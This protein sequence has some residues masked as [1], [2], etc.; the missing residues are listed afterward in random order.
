MENHIQLYLTYKDQTPSAGTAATDLIGDWTVT[1]GPIVYQA[2]DS[3]VADNAMLVAC[4]NVTLPDGSTRKMAVVAIAGTAAMSTVD[5]E[6]EDG[7]AGDGSAITGVVPWKDFIATPTHAASPPVA[8]EAVISVGT[9]TGLCTLLGMTDPSL[10]NAPTL[11]QHLATLDADILVVTGHSLGGALSA[12]LGL[13]LVQTGTTPQIATTYVYPTAGAS[14]GNDVFART[15][16]QALPA[17]RGA[18]AWQSWNLDIWNTLDVVP[19]AWSTVGTDPTI[20]TLHNVNV[21][22]GNDD[23]CP[24]R[25]LKIPTPGHVK[26]LSARLLGWSL[27]STVA[28]TPIPGASFPG[29][30]VNVIPDHPGSDIGMPVLVPPVDFIGFAAQALYQHGMAYGIAIFADQTRRLPEDQSDPAPN[31]TREG[32]KELLGYFETLFKAKGE[33]PSCPNLEPHV[34]AAE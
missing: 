25:F 1:W 33:R 18:V 22:Y 28:Y 3:D 4:S 29:H 14:P 10:T 17:V 9:A 5:W 27:D 7:A 11:R 32:L 21:I 2:E 31:V 16:A 20:R 12:A 8:G 6:C 23:H 13:Y 19:Q 26:A 24:P 15:F 30:T 34:E